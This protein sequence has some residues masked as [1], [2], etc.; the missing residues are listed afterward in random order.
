M[1]LSQAK[2]NPLNQLMSK[3][4]FYYGCMNCGKSLSLLSKAYGFRERGIDVLLIKSTIDTRDS[5]VIRSR[6]LSVEEQ[7]L[8]ISQEEDVFVKVSQ[9]LSDGPDYKWI[10]VDEC[11]FLTEKQVDQLAK[12]VDVLNINVICYGLRTDFKMNLFEGSKWL[13]ATADT[14]EETKTICWCG[15]KATT[16]ARYNEEGIVKDG[17]QIML[18]GNDSYISLCRKHFMEGNLGK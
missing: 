12:V 8:P 4:Y 14:I 10:L 3:L 9:A 13:F 16:N 2:S 17:A 1:R 18:G 7:C 15:K 6:A 5:G 11:Q